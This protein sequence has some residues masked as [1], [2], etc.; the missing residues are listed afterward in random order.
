METQAF[1]VGIGTRDP[2]RLRTFYETTVGLAPRFEFAAGAFAVN[3]AADPC[4]LIEAHD[5]VAESAR[6]PQRV[7]LNLVVANARA[8]EARLRAAGVEFIR[9]V[10]EDP[11]GLFATFT[12]PDGN[13]CQL[14]QL[15]GEGAT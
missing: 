5:E 12:D 9:A 15:R 11:E 4:L 7:L 2:E 10:Y 14:V 1:V 6:E 8:E 13:Y 3:A